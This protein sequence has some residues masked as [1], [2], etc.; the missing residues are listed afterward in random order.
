MSNQFICHV[1]CYILYPLNK[2]LYEFVVRLPT[3][4]SNTCA[5]VT[6]QLYRHRA[7]MALTLY[8]AVLYLYKLWRLKA[9]VQFEIIITVSIYSFRFIRIPI[10]VVYGH[11]KYFTPILRGST[12]DVVYRRQILTSKVDL[13]AVRG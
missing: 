2:I 3:V 12:L 13:R 11:Y 10:L 4:L 5:C 6:Y 8:N 7:L 9:F 1:L